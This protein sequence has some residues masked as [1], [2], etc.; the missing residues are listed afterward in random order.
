MPRRGQ[1]QGCG[2]RVKPAHWFFRGDVAYSAGNKS[3]TVGR[4]TPL[5]ALTVGARAPAGPTV[6]D[7]RPTLTE[8]AVAVV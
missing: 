7:V 3:G 2:D 6:E 1:K 8:G 5:D 4:V